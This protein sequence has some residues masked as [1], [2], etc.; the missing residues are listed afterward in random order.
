VLAFVADTRND[1]L[2]C[3]NVETVELLTD[4]PVGVGS[5]FR[6]HQHLDRP[7]GQRIHFDVDVE[8]THLDGHSVSWTVSDRFQDRVITIDVEPAQGGSRI[9]QVTR[10]AF[11][12]PPGLTRWVYPLLARRIFKDQFRHLAARYANRDTGST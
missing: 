11:K 1:P 7:G 3:S 6:F 9:T 8:L 5:K 2:W 12:R 10:A 4:E